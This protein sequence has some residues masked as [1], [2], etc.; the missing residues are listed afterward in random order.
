MPRRLGGGRDRA[1]LLEMIREAL[2]EMFREYER[3]RVVEQWWHGSDWVPR[4]TLEKF[5]VLLREV[6][7]EDAQPGNREV[8]CEG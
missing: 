5:G 7:S 4:R 2:K 1:E 8:R 6:D 3:L